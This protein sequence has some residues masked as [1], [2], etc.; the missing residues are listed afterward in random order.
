MWPDYCG[1]GQKDSDSVRCIQRALIGKGKSIPAGA[2]GN[3]G[4]QTIAAIKS[5]TGGNGLVGPNTI[6]KILEGTPY[7]L[8]S[9]MGRKVRKW[10]GGKVYSG[11]VFYG[12]RNSE[13]V[14]N[15]QQRLIDLGFSI[16]AGPTGN[17]FGQTKTAAVAFQRY[18]GLTPDGI[19]GPQTL[20]ALFV[21]PQQHYLIVW[22]K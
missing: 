20:R 22:G 21:A 12:N 15:V 9:G 6:R 16:P 5:L 17:F 10:G 13:S 7:Q 1:W 4:P 2:T 3:F 18:V 11:W 14:R 19:V 8:Q